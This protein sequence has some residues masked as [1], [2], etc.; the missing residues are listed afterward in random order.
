MTLAAAWLALAAALVALLLQRRQARKLAQITEMYWQ[1]KYDLGEVKA[2]VA[3]AE[4][5]PPPMPATAFVPL[6]AVKRPPS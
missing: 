4:P 1:L 2:A 3:P 5:E 6:A